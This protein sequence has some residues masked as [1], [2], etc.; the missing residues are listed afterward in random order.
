M[1]KRSRS[2]LKSWLSLRKKISSMSRKSRRLTWH[3]SKPKNPTIKGWKHKSQS[4]QDMFVE[5]LWRIQTMF[6]LW[7]RQSLLVLKS[8]S[9]VGL[10][11][12]EAASGT[13]QTQRASRMQAPRNCVS[14][15]KTS[16]ITAKSRILSLLNNNRRCR[17]SKTTIASSWTKSETTLLNCLKF[18]SKSKNVSKKNVT[19]WKKN[20][21]QL[22]GLKLLELHL[23]K[24]RRLMQFKLKASRNS[25][26]KTFS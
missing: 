16:K 2:S 24:R 15:S 26:S 22:R 19:S 1:K 8:L 11:R 23:I 14:W 10:Q 18:L 6:H 20:W 3:V 9:V 7:L 4:L 25:K 21:R 13:S 12:L 17:R 5:P